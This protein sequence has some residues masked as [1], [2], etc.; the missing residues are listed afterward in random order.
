M[1]IINAEITLQEL[2]KKQKKAV[3]DQKKIAYIYFVPYFWQW[4]VMYV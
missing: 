1:G 2:G 4:P 3:W